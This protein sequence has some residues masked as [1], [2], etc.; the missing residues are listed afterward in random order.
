MTGGQ[1]EIQDIKPYSG[2]SD[3]YDFYDSYSERDPK[4]YSDDSERDKRSVVDVLIRY[5]ANSV[6]DM[7]NLKSM[8]VKDTKVTPG[9][10]TLV[11]LVNSSTTSTTTQSTIDKT[12]LVTFMDIMN[13]FQTGND[14]VCLQENLQIRNAAL[15]WGLIALVLLILLVVSILVCCYCCPCC[16]CY[17]AE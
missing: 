11:P 13:H 16:Y 6:V 10:T 1:A 15:F 3:Y 8:L 4:T 5:P 17:N 14:I 2:S 9:V 12:L 7:N